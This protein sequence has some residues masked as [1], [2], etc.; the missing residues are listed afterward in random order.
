VDGDG[1]AQAAGQGQQFKGRLADGTVHVVDVDED[2]THYYS[3][4]G[5]PGSIRERRLHC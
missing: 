1:L 4:A 2:F 3:C 5:F